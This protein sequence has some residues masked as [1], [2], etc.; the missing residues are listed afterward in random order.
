MLYLTGLKTPFAIRVRSSA[1]IAGRAV[2][3]SSLSALL[4]VMWKALMRDRR[5][6][7]F[8]SLVGYLDAVT[9]TGG[10][11]RGSVVAVGS[12]SG[13]MGDSGGASGVSSGSGVEIVSAGMMS[14]GAAGAISA[15]VGSVLGWSGLS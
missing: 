13:G 1:S 15:A 7:G 4:A 6:G 8:Q 14:I 10:A 12:V 5:L 11:A 3:G 9:G 2:A